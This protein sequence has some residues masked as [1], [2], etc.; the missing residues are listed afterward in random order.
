MTLLRY[1][2]T[3]SF[4]R[5]VLA[6][7]LLVVAATPASPIEAGA[8]VQAAPADLQQLQSGGH[9]L[10]IAAGRMVVAPNS[11]WH[12][13]LGGSGDDWGSTSQWIVVATYM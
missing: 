1:V 12:T 11:T 4:V 6:A 5:L 8:P 3:L 13:F 2:S 7:A 10:G 9:I